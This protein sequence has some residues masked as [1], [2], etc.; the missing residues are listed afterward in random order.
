MFVH[1][2]KIKMRIVGKGTLNVNNINNIKNVVFNIQFYN[3][4]QQK[5]T[6]FFPLLVK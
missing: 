1:L 2:K 3:S 6:L 4:I 5:K